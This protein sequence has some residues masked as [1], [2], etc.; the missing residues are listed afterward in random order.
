[1]LMVDD[2]PFRVTQLSTHVHIVQALS[3]AACDCEA[4]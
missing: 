3:Y 1:M 4:M 2:H